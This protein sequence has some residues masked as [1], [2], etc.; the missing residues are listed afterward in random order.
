MTFVTVQCEAL[1]AAAAQLEGIGSA[2]TAQNSAAAAPTTGVVPA[3]AD[4]VSALQSALFSAYGTLYQQVSAQATAIHQMFVNALSTSAGSYGTTE[5]MNAATANSS[6]SGF[7]GLI[8]ALLGSGSSSGSSGLGGFLGASGPLGPSGSPATIG[9]IAT[10]NWVAG[11][12]DLLG[13]AA[14]G[15]LDFPKTAADVLPAAGLE[16]AVLAGAVGPGGSAGFGGAPVLAGLGQA[17]AVGGLSVPPSWATGIAPAGGPSPAT[18]VSTGWATA[19]AAAGHAPMSTVPSGMPLLP[20]A[21]KSGG[22]GVPRYGVK[23]VVMP[24][25]AVV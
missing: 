19:P 11:S 1:S 20:G 21:G 4:Q 13:L 16:S 15:L 8:G 9:N 10:G 14:G 7:S 5:A 6:G 24:K 12:S 18:L 3:A 23:P 22:F 25:P 17:S 2:V